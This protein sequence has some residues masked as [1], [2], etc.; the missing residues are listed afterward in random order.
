MSHCA[1]SDELRRRLGRIVFTSG[2]EVEER[3]LP[4]ADAPRRVCGLALRSSAPDLVA[5]D[6]RII[7]PRTHT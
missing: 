7:A 3:Q 5:G 2:K 6:E 1:R 4:C